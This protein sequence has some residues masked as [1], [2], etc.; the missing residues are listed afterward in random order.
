MKI[1]CLILAMLLTVC[2]HAAPH[3]PFGE[4]T[5]LEADRENLLRFVDGAGAAYR[6]CDIMG[7]Q[8]SSGAS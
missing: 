5:M 7:R 4:G 2:L 3:L 8:L 6:L 1:H